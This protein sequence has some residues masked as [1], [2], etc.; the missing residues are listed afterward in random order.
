MDS[1]TLSDGRVVQLGE[2]AHGGT[3]NDTRFGVVGSQDVVVKVED[4]H[5]QLEDERVAL[6]FLAG[7]KVRV[8]QVVASGVT[9]AGRPFLVMTREKGVRAVTPAGWGRLGRDLACLLD[10]SADSC[11]FPRIGSDD[12]AADHRARL[13]VV[14]SLLDPSLANEI[15][16]AIDTISG[17]E[18]LVITHG[19]PGSGNYL[20]SEDDDRPGVVLDWESASIAPVG[21]DAGRAVF[22]GLM[23]LGHT[24]IPNQ[25]AAA[26]IRG[27]TEQAASLSL[28][29]ELLR[30]W[31][32]VA[33]LQFIHGRHMRP[34]VPERTPAAAVR[35]LES[36][37]A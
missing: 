14:G 18:R 30:A 22:I 33:G 1:L 32:I 11:P 35:V 37:L 25:L 7:T 19:D 9:G 13:D 10:V 6:D 26:L 24:G 17:V 4:T 8:P 27:Y 5:G 12:F 36:Y 20:D 28:D 23:D 2:R 16:R 31:T 15:E 34:L 3:K 29:D 21:L